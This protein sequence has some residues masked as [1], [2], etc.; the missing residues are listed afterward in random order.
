[1]SHQSFIFAKCQ[2]SQV[3]R[4][5]T[6]VG[7]WAASSHRRY[8]YDIRPVSATNC[9]EPTNIRS[10]ID[11]PKIVSLVPTY[12]FAHVVFHRPVVIATF[13]HMRSLMAEVV[14]VLKG[15]LTIKVS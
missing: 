9:Y 10:S 13:R 1:M 4:L 8:V 3:I 15:T 14:N 11:S 12:F 6:S 7:I 2:N 5:Y